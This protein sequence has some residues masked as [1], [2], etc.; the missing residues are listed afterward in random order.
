MFYQRVTLAGLAAL[1]FTL[2]ARVALASPT[3]EPLYLPQGTTIHPTSDRVLMVDQGGLIAATIVTGDDR[4]RVAIWRGNRAT[5]LPIVRKFEQSWTDNGF[6]TLGAVLANGS[7]VVNA[8]YPFQGAYMGTWIHTFMYAGQGYREVHFA[9]CKLISAATDPTVEGASGT[10]LAVTFEPL[11][12]IQ[13]DVGDFAPNAAI[14]TAHGCDVI[15]RASIRAIRGKYIAGFQ[16]FLDKWVAD[17]SF[18]S[19]QQIDVAV[20][21]I[22]HKL[23]KLGKGVALGV[24]SGGACVGYRDISAYRQGYCC[25]TLTPRAMLWNQDRSPSIL[26]SDLDSVAYAIDDAN[27]VVGSLQDTSKRHYAFLYHDGKVERLDDL[28]QAPRWRFEAAFGFTPDG[29]ILGIG[30]HDGIATAFIVH[31]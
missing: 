4:E 31:L 13:N 25:R 9:P 1:T 10:D 11:S 5:V 3:V 27:R 28:V 30:T 23:Q 16:R 20:R 17:N 22:G 29:G 12:A 15:G 14:I 6:Q 8:G 18:E 2:V 7:V 26:V 24:N 19:D 21:W